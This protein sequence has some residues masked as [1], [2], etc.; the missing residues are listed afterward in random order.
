MNKRRAL[1]AC[2]GVRS[3][4]QSAAARMGWRG[5]EKREVAGLLPWVAAALSSRYRVPDHPGKCRRR[6][7]RGRG[8]EL[9]QAHCA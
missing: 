2:S 4:S 8:T 7:G 1:L 9:V 5:E 3:R 6:K